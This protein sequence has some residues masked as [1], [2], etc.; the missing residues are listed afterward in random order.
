VNDPVMDQNQSLRSRAA[1][2]IVLLRDIQIEIAACGT[3]RG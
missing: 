3:L 1:L 2:F